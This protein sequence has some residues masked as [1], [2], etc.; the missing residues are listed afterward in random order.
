MLSDKVESNL[1]VTLKLLCSSPFLTKEAKKR[2]KQ[3]LS[4]SFGEKN[5]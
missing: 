2:V 1:A 5:E 3:V 4:N